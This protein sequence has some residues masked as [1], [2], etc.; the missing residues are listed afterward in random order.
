MNHQPV[1]LYYEE[2]GQGIPL[3]LLHGFPLD[4]T[5]WAPV[6]PLLKDHARVIT[7]DLRGHGRSPAPEGEYSMREM[8]DDVFDLYRRL[9]LDCAIVV[10]HS[11]GGYVAIAFALAYP[12]YISALGLVASHA[13]ADQPER[14]QARYNTAQKVAKKGVRVVA[15]TMPANL[16]GDPGIARQIQALIRQTPPAGIIGALKGM[17]ARPDN[18]E[19]LSN[20]QVPAIVISGAE[21]ALI[22]RELNETTTQLLG[23]AWQ[24]VVPNT[25]HLPMME[26][27]QIVADALLNLV[28]AAENCGKTADF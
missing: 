20:I 17:A 18:T 11:M 4:H 24:V 9:N 3:I 2:A 16:T 28:Q 25:R 26:A 27:P 10:G 13:A 14:R 21:D 22:S 1:E 7:P 23:R 19:L 15:D 6:V 8:A 12:H 5:I